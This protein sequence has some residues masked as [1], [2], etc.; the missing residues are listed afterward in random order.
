MTTSVGTALVAG[1]TTESPGERAATKALS[2]L[3]GERVDFCQVFCSVEYDFDRV[4]ADVR[5]V[6]GPDAA[7]VGCSANGSFTQEGCGTGVTVGLVESDSLSFYTGLGTGLRENVS[8]AVREAVADLPSAVDDHPYA[9]AINLHDGLSGVGEELALVTQQK[10]GP[11]VSIVGGSA[12]DDHRLE[13]TYVFHDDEVV[14]DAVVLAM[15]GAQQRPAV[16]VAH[17]HEP[18]SGP[19]RVTH[20]DGPVVYELDGD[21]A[22]DV[23]KDAVRDRVREAFGVSIDELDHDDTRLQEILCEFEFGIN[24]GEQYKMRWPWT[25]GDDGAMHFAVDVPEGT[26]LRVMHGRPEAQ[27]ESARETA[28]RALRD[29]GDVEIA[30]GFIYD[31][32][33]RRIALGDEFETA[34]GEMADELGVPFAGFET[35]GEICMGPGQFSGFHNTTT[36]ALLLP[37]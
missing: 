18:L 24:Q 1:D 3:P 37:A 15:I 25:E 9:A 5:R 22:F 10:L 12:A 30:G 35:Y 19:V 11:E 2:Q 13:A 33:C 28:R 20:S 17:G 14:E 34:V 8:R 23:W 29:A 4:L 36:V 31:C 6:V 16:A 27:I 26:V 7:V 21:P 32:A